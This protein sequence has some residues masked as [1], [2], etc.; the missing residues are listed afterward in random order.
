MS[1]NKDDKDK[2]DLPDFFSINSKLPSGVR[3]KSGK[4]KKQKSNSNAFQKKV[5]KRM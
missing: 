1:D 2:K 5:K 4:G 3:Q